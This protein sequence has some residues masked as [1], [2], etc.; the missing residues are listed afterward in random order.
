MQ[1]DFTQPTDRAMA[2]SSLE[3]RLA[4]AFHTSVRRLQDILHSLLGWPTCLLCYDYVFYV[5]FFGLYIPWA[6][7]RL[8]NFSLH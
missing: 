4:E 1:L 5:F 8:P 7:L 6:N 3:K 2:F